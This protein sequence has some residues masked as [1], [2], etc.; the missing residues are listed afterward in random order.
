MLLLREVDT[1][2]S[3]SCGKICLLSWKERALFFTGTCLSPTFS[4]SLI[5]D[6]N[7]NTSRTSVYYGVMSDVIV[8]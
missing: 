8:V 4:R 5:H 7:V 2:F 3:D 1:F 6:N